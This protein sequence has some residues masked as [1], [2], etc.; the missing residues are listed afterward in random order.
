MAKC[1]KCLREAK[2]PNKTWK[3]GQFKV[4]AYS[5]KNCGT[6]FRNYSREGKHSFTLKLVKGKAFVKV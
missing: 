1:P 3:Y 6:Q 5:C 4:Q 2:D